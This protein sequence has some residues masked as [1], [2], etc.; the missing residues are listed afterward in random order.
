M[1]GLE[2]QDYLV[3]GLVRVYRSVVISSLRDGWGVGAGFGF[4]II[5]APSLRP[6][7]LVLSLLSLLPSLLFLCIDFFIA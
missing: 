2:G 3:I 6:W 1:I 5:V 4:I 7:S